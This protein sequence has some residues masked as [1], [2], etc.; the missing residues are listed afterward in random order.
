MVRQRDD[1][2]KKVAL[3]ENDNDAFKS[4]GGGG[5]VRKMNRV[6]RPA[7]SSHI[8]NFDDEDKENAKRETMVRMETQSIPI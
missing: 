7:L 4:L 8:P 3:L 1:L 6:N 2:R 5:L